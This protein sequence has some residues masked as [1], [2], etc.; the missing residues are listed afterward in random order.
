MPRKA[1][2]VGHRVIAFN[3]AITLRV[4]SGAFQRLGL[5]ENPKLVK[6]SARHA[7]W[8][9]TFPN[10][11]TGIGLLHSAIAQVVEFTADEFYALAKAGV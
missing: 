5:A 1:A 7:G 10:D 3:V 6:R 11:L 2:R 4:M 9:C 8:C